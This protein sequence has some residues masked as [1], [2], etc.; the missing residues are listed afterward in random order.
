KLSQAILTG[1]RLDGNRVSVHPNL[2]GEFEADARYLEADS[3]SLTVDKKTLKHLKKDV[4][5]RQ[6]VIYELIQTELHHVRTLRIMGEVYSKGLQR[7][8]QLEPATLQKLFPVLDE[9]LDLHSR[10]LSSLAR[11]TCGF[12]VQK[13]GDTLISQVGLRSRLSSVWFYGKFCSRHSDAV[14]LYKELHN[15]DKHFQAFIKKKMSSSI[16]RRL[17]IPECILLVT[18]RITKYPVLIQRILQLTKGKRGSLHHNCPLLYQKSR[19]IYCS[20]N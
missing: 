16:V 19:S 18:Q 20:I 10:F 3:W 2:M 13:I 12:L 8:L 4:V 6:D 15:K 17:S 1:P 14:N 11:R 7:E 9:L 5:K